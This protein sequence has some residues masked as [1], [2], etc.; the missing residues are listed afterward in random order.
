MNDSTEQVMK[1][2]QPRQPSRGLR[3][4]IFATEPAAAEVLRAPLDWASFTRWLVPALGCFV[5][6]AGMALDPSTQVHGSFATPTSHQIAYS[7]EAGRTGWGGDKNTIPAKNLE[8]TVG[9]P[10]RSSSHS[11]VGSGTNSLRK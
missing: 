2:W 8:W 10:S 11:F 3:S 7:I 4:R 5:V 6:F 9:Q 1:A